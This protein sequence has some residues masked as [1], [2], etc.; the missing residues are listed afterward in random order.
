MDYILK[1]DPKEVA[2]VI[3]EN[4][5]RVDRGVISFT[6]CQPETAL[7]TNVP[8]IGDS[9]PENMELSHNIGEIVPKVSEIENDDK[10]VECGD[11][12]EVN[13]DDVKDIEE[14]DTKETPN[15]TPKKTRTEKSE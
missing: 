4:R 11:I 12:K 7:D 3:Q 15:P 6:P 1:G 2:K 13:L 5:I 8:K 14:T 9:V 10:I